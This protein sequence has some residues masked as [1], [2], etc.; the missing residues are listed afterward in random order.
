M[1]WRD[2]VEKDANGKLLLLL[3]V[4]DWEQV[5]GGPIR[6][7]YDEVENMKISVNVPGDLT[8]VSNGR[9]QSKT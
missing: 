1:G 7:T 8:N 9:L 6:I 2:N 3:P 4:K 5:Y